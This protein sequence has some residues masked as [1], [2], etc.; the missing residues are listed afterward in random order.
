MPPASFMA[1]DG[2]CSPILRLRLLSST[3]IPS[4][5]AIPSMSM[6][7]SASLEAGAQAREKT[8]SIAVNSRMPG[9][10]GIFSDLICMAGAFGVVSGM[11]TFD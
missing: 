4:M 5:P 2:D 1:K 9:T 6:D 10:K 3:A 11:L 7:I 8:A